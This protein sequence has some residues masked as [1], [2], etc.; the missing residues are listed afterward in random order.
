MRRIGV[1]RKRVVRNAVLGAFALVLLAAPALG[2]SLKDIRAHEAEDAA[3]ARE[4]AYTGSVCGHSVS[5]RIDWASAS[6][7]PAEESLA[8][9]CDGALSAVEALCRAG[10]KGVVKSFICAGDGSGPDL[11]GGT[12]RYG[13]SPARGG[14]EETRAYL[15]GM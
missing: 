14:Y 13:A 15:E 2:Q 11:S 6:A 4:A 1:E 12:L 8:G 7:W 9:A 5:A 10:R 3:L